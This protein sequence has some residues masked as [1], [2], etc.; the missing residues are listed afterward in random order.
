MRLATWIDD[1]AFLL[2]IFWR[3][4]VR[5]SFCLM[6]ARASPGP[7]PVMFWRVNDLFCVSLLRASLTATPLPWIRWR[8][9]KVLTFPTPEEVSVKR[10]RYTWMVESYKNRHHVAQSFRFIR[11]LLTHIIVKLK[12]MSYVHIDMLRHRPNY[13]TSWLINMTNQQLWRQSYVAAACVWQQRS[14]YRPTAAR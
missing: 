11:R 6:F 2:V 10:C 12:T 13:D 1:E 7:G 9:S 8:A 3:A 4:S 5:R 14:L